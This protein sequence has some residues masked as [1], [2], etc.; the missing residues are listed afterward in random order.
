MGSSTEARSKDVNVDRRSSAGG[1][2]VNAL[3]AGESRPEQSRRMQLDQET[4]RHIA[5]CVES[6][7]DEFTGR[8]APARVELEVRQVADQ[9]AAEARLGDFIPTLAHRFGR[10]RLLAVAAQN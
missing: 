5:R 2:V 1:Y 3:D 4:Q 10:E 8:V 6:L 7:T 9:L